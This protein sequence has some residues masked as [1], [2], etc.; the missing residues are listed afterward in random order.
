MERIE[1]HLKGQIDR[2]WSDL[3]GGLRIDHNDQ[4]E[5]VLTGLLRDQS[6]LYGLLFNLSDLGIRLISLVSTKVIDLNPEET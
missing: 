6:A 2:N 4:G 1:I 5:T 3:L